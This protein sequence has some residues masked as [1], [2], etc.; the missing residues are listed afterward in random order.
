MSIRLPQRINAAPVGPDPSSFD[1]STLRPLDGPAAAEYISPAT[2]SRVTPATANPIAA[3]VEIGRGPTSGG[4]VSVV[5][6]AE[7]TLHDEPSVGHP[8]GWASVL[9]P[10]FRMTN[11]PLRV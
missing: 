10:E 6:V 3:R 5:G 2:N 9:P 1:G 7:E 11:T 4:E 8:S